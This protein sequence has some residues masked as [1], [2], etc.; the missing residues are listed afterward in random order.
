MRMIYRRNTD[1][2]DNTPHISANQR[3]LICIHEADDK[4]LLHFKAEDELISGS[5]EKADTG[6][7]HR[8][9]GIGS[10]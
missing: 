4:S 8:C 7:R 10:V 2:V 5:Q 3:L 9:E 1:D 6:G